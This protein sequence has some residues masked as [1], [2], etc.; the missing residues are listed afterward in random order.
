MKKDISCYSLLYDTGRVCR[1]TKSVQVARLDK[2]LLSSSQVLNWAGYY[3]IME[4]L[5][6]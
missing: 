6:L 3:V 1:D 2:E 4:I 5:L